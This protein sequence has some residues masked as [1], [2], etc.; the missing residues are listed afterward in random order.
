MKKLLL[1][2]LSIG[3]LSTSA[4]AWPGAQNPNP[5]QPQIPVNT[6]ESRGQLDGDNLLVSVE[7]RNDTGHDMECD[8]FSTVR[9]YR[10]GDISG[11]YVDVKQ[12][13]ERLLMEKWQHGNNFTQVNLVFKSAYFGQGFKPSQPS[14]RLKPACKDLEEPGQNPGQ[15]PAPHELCDPEYNSCGNWSCQASRQNPSQCASQNTDWSNDPNVWL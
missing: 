3:C 15:G 10:G 9:A 2:A 11:S 13:V 4:L 1:A 6:P 5:G 7:L 14:Q 12:G 8:V